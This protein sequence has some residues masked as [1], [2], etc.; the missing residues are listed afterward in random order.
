MRGGG[1]LVHGASCDGAAT[2]GAAA[3]PLGA[4]GSH[5]ARNAHRWCAV[6]S[7]FEALDAYGPMELWGS[8]GAQVRVVTIAKQRG[9]VASA[10]GPQSIAQFTY[11]DA[12][13]LDLIVVPGGIGVPALLDDSPTLEF[14]RKRAA[15]AEILMSVCNGASILAAAGLLDRR[16]RPPTRHTGRSLRRDDRPCTGYPVHAGWMRVTW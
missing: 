15:K 7:G 4:G 11:R 12:P 13:A 8:L 14:V 10:Q 5:D 6:V 1:C 9:P 2:R 3:D 16:G